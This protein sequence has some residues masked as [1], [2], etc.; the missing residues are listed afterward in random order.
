METQGEEPAEAK[1]ASPLPVD[2]DDYDSCEDGMDSSM[3]LLETQNIPIP[4][5]SSNMM[6]MSDLPLS[7]SSPEHTPIEKMM[8][9]SWILIYIC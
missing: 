2:D 5:P 6:D 9:K 3:P 1:T 4:I 8:T 7:Q